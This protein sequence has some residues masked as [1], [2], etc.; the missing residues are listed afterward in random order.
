MQINLFFFKN[1]AN[2][3]DDK[4]AEGPITAES[5]K[6]LQ[7]YFVESEHLKELEIEAIRDGLSY[8][9]E[10]TFENGAVY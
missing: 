7:N 8:I 4:L 2:Y 9:R 3:R 10:L 5:P 6:T 1:N